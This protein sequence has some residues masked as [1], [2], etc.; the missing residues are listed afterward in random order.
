MYW[1]AQLLGVLGMRRL[2]ILLRLQ[3]RVGLVGL[4]GGES[5]K[6]QRLEGLLVDGLEGL[7][8]W[9]IIHYIDAGVT[10]EAGS[11]SRT[12]YI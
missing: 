11:E 9:G 4:E 7:L 1:L 5:R 12:L 6:P 3:S 8:G 10:I 2:K